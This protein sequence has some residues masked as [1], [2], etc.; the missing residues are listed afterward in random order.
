MVSQ[1][2]FLRIFNYDTMEIVGRARSYFGGFLCVCWSP[3]GK[4]IVCGGEDD[5]ITVYS[6]EEKRVVVRGQGH[7]SWVSVVV[8][9]IKSINDGQCGGKE[10]CC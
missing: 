2:G 3:D 1:D 10:R 7:K 8:S 5:L 9:Y 6:V 4:Y